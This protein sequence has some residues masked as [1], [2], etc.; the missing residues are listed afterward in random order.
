MFSLKNWQRKHL[1]ASFSPQLGDLNDCSYDRREF[2]VHDTHQLLFTS[3]IRNIRDANSRQKQGKTR[4]QNR[5]FLE[6]I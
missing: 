5:P 6:K 3:G 2:I 4:L 1:L